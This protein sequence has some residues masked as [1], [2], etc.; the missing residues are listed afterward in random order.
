MIAGEGG[1]VAHSFSQPAGPTKQFHFKGVCLGKRDA[2]GGGGARAITYHTNLPRPSREAHTRLAMLKEGTYPEFSRAARARL[3]VL[4][5]EVGGRW[6]SEAANFIRLLT[7][8]RAR[9]GTASSREA[10]ISA[11]TQRWSALLSFAATRSFDF[12]RCQPPVL[13]PSLAPQTLKEI[14]PFSAICWQTPLL[15]RHLPAACLQKPA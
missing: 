15:L 3:V 7:R 8:A 5:L 10:S 4:A 12:F 6:G 11:Y 2:Q 9:N 13:P 14:H 1:R